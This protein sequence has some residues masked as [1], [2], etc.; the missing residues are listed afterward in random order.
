MIENNLK[1]ISRHL[2][3]RFP[4]TQ[5]SQDL[6]YSKGVVSEYYNNKRELSENFKEQFENYYKIKFSDFEEQPPD[7]ANSP[8]PN[9]PKHMRE[10]LNAQERV[11]KSMEITISTL[12]DRIRDLEKEN[13]FSTKSLPER[14]ESDKDK[15][16]R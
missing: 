11:I 12:Q 9:N 3:L 7:G 4:V 6:G 8:N 14:N 2:K 16:A 15:K 5:I 13:F 10:L 1:K